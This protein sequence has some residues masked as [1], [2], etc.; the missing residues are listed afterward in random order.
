LNRFFPELVLLI[1]R[2]GP[3]LFCTNDEWAGAIRTSFWST[4]GLGTLCVAKRM[5]CA[6]LAAAFSNAPR[7]REE[8]G[9]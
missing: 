7:G 4:I 5:E 9:S 1:L 2:I 8:S 3:A 6:R